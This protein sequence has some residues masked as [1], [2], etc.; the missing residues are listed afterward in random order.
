MSE[1]EELPPWERLKSLD[2]GEL[3]DINH[4]VFEA[5]FEDNQDAFTTLS[6]FIENSEPSI[7]IRSTIGHI[8]M[9]SRISLIK[10]RA[11]QPPLSNGSALITNRRQQWKPPPLD[12]TQISSP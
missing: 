12:Q 9:Y 3:N 5:R 4:D 2:I 1:K 11:E 7:V 8:L 10:S 6:S